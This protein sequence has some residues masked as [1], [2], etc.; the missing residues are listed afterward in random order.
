MTQYGPGRGRA[1]PPPFREVDTLGIG[2]VGNYVYIYC[3]DGEQHLGRSL[4]FH[5]AIAFAT[6]ILSE[7]A[8]LGRGVK[9]CKRGH[10]MTED[11][12]IYN[13]HG[14]RRC[15]TCHRLNYYKRKEEHRAAREEGLEG[16]APS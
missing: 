14:T 9:C 16:R 3:K 7:A 12:T 2:T 1:L 8:V 15:R 10:P 5:E 13:S 4:D 6:R 11:N